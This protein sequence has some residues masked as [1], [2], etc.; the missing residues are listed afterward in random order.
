MLFLHSRIE[1][2]GKAVGVSNFKIHLEDLIKDAQIEPMVNQVEY[3]P[4]LSRKELQLNCQQNNI[5][6]KTRCETD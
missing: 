4:R 2:K 6:E 1:G 5:H 3:H